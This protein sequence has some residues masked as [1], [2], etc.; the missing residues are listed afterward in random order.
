VKKRGKKKEYEAW[1]L[2]L[3]FKACR[4]ARGKRRKREDTN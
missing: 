4:R 3:T 2:W 1:K